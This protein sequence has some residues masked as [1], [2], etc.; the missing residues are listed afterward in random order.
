M[1]TTLPATWTADPVH[2]TAG[3]AVRHMVVA[4]FR[5]GFDRIEGSLDLI[6][7][8]PRLVGEV[9]VSSISVKDEDL[10]AHLQSPEFFDAQTH[11]RLSFVSRE[12]VRQG[13]DVTI[14]GD[15]TIKG[16]TLPV[17]ARGT[18]H[19][20]EADLSGD[21]RV[22]IDVETTIDRTRYGLNW[23]AP[24]PKGGFALADEVTLSVHLELVPATS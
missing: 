14:A 12:I 22:G 13:D 4:T 5:G 18:W 9:D 10:Y 19:E 2:S 21:P 16:T 1:A 24:L 23:N 20:V 7:D 6:G 8:R 17:T 15:L 3:F 11:P